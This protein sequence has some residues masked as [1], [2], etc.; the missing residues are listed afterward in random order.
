MTLKGR[1][2]FC[3]KMH[4]SFGAHHE[5]M[6]EDRPVAYFQL[7]AIAY[8]FRD[9]NISLIVYELIFLKNV[10]NVTKTVDVIAL[11]ETML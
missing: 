9:I 1:Y 11:M 2:A 8:G 7:L 6:N 4:A 3:F 5:N 10:S